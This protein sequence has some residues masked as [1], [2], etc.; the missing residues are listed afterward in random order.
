M[1]WSLRILERT[2]TE[3]KLKLLIF[4]EMRVVSFAS[5]GNIYNCEL[6]LI[7]LG[8]SMYKIKI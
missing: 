4:L 1:N 8:L 6:G 2:K 5:L 3:Y 7:K